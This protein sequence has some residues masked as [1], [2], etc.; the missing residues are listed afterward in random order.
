MLPN[1]SNI[2]ERKGNETMMDQTA[3]QTLS[4][5]M[6]IISTWDNG[7][8]T[9]CTANSVIQITSKPATLAVSLHLDNYTNACIKEHG[10]F[11]VSVLPE[12]IEPRIIGTFG[13]QSGKT[14]DKFADI[15]YTL[16]EHLPV[17]PNT[18]AQ[19]VCRIKDTMQTDTHTVFLGEI[20]AAQN[21]NGTPMTYEYYHRVIKGKAPKNAPTYVDA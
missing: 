2:A 9:G 15:D 19:I 17:L 14:A 1:K 3:L 21:G 12:D 18:C 8:P 4:Y 7:R 10:M 16:L 6:Y 11:S 13:Y 20:L 5:G